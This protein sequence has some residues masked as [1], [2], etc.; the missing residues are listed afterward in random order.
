MIPWSVGKTY[1]FNHC[2]E[3]DLHSAIQGHPLAYLWLGFVDG[4]EVTNFMRVDKK[5]EHYSWS[6]YTES[7]EWFPMPFKHELTS[8]ESLERCLYLAPLCFNKQDGLPLHVGDTIEVFNNW[9]GV[10]YLPASDPDCW[11]RTV[12]KLGFQDTRPW[13]WVKE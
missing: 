10:G 1:N 13:R 2:K 6:F 11:H 9:N 5:G 4:R 12:V 3:F 8:A 7:G